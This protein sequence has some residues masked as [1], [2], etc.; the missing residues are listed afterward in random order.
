MAEAR[1]VICTGVGGV[2]SF[3]RDGE[4][5][6]IVQKGDVEELA[7]R[8]RGLLA[9]PDERRRLGHA[10]LHDV[11]EQYPLAP[12]VEETVAAYEGAGAAAPAAE[13]E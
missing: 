2:V 11:R 5:G 7:S 9:A 4:N 13:S 10:A 1:P 6:L 3:V 8:I 12:M